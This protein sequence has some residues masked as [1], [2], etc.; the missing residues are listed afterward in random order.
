MNFDKTRF[1]HVAA[2]VAVTGAGLSLGRLGFCPIPQTSSAPEGFLRG[3]AF[4]ISFA[5]IPLV[6]LFICSVTIYSRPAAV[7]V[8]FFESIVDGYL[9]NACAGLIKDGRD[10][11]ICIFMI[12]VRV[13][14]LYIFLLLTVRTLEFRDKTECQPGS[15][16]TF[17]S[18]QSPAFYRDYSS[19]AGICCLLGLFAYTILYYTKG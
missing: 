4:E 19:V 2:S 7:S 3:F 18:G 16:H 5:L 9:I 15:I 1:A 14:F 12:C 13:C 6:I 8:L 17:L 10:V 11:P